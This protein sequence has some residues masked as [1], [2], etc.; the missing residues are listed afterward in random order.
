MEKM[1]NNEAY[2]LYNG[3]IFID[4]D[5]YYFSMVINYLRND[6]QMPECRNN[7]EQI[8]FQNELKYWGLDEHHVRIYRV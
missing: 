4:R 3:K 5:P 1:I 8:M 6:L 2:D 7:Y